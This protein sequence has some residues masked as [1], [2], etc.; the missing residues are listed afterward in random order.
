MATQVE[1]T[2][3]RDWGSGLIDAQSLDLPA[4]KYRWV[5]GLLRRNPRGKLLEV[6]CNGGR[7]LKTLR[8]SVPSLEYFGCD[9]DEAAIHRAAGDDGIRVCV[10][11]GYRL[12]FRDHAFDYVLVMDYLEHVAD[13]ASALKEI[14]RVLAP[15]GM[16][17][18]FIP[19]EGE[20]FSF[21]NL[22]RKIFHWDVKERTCGHFPLRRRDLEESLR[23]NGLSVLSRRY[24]YHFFGQWMDFAF[25]WLVAKSR[26]LSEWWWLK[27]K[28]YHQ[29][30]GEEGLSSKFGNWILS[31]GNFFAYLESSVLWKCPFGATGWHLTARKYAGE[32][33]VIPGGKRTP[34]L[35]AAE[36]GAP[37][38][39]VNCRLK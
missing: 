5:R 22:H 10:A 15:G 11:D 27:S 2:V 12:P 3:M 6:G 35:Q 30:R 20:R 31:I 25:F 26:K 28:Y 8:H 37:I 18:A 36:T 39:Q 17:V 29:E 14:S 33:G 24:S 9:R 32:T 7:F 38:L 1:N 4:L 19:C 21:Y 23:L 13:S 34:E 16:F